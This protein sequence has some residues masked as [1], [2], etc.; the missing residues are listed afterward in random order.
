MP[1]TTIIN[2]SLE[3]AAAHAAAQ[4][5]VT[6]PPDHPLLVGNGLTIPTTTMCAYWPVAKPVI[7][8]LQHFLPSWTAWV[9]NILVAV[10]DKTC[11]GV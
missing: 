8:S 2:E 6:L 9:V 4:P 11:P 1:L 5:A 10:G 3:G 7:M